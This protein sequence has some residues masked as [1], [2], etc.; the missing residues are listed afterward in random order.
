[1]GKLDQNRFNILKIPKF[2]VKI[3]CEGCKL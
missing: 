3:E 2:E 1:M